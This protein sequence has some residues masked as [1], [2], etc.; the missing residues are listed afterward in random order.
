M[1]FAKGVTEFVKLL[2]AK[3]TFVVFCS[4]RDMSFSFYK[5]AVA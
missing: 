1:Y 5:K 4:Q 3:K 2:L